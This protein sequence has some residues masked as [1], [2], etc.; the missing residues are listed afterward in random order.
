MTATH[1]LLQKKI[2]FR[3]QTSDDQVAGQSYPNAVLPQ[4]AENK[5]RRLA[6]IQSVVYIDGSSMCASPRI[7]SFSRFRETALG[8]WLYNADE[9]LCRENIAAVID[10]AHILTQDMYGIPFGQ[11]LQALEALRRHIPDIPITGFAAPKIL[12]ICAI[13]RI[14]PEQ[15]LR[16][17]KNAGLTT[18]SG[19]GITL[20]KVTGVFETLEM[21]DWLRVHRA[22]QSA[23]LRSFVT[24]PFAVH[25]VGADL[26]DRIPQLVQQLAEIQQDEHLFAGVAAR[27]V[28]RSFAGQ[29]PSEALIVPVYQLLREQF[30]WE[31]VVSCNFQELGLAGTFAA[32]YAGADVI[33]A[34]FETAESAKQVFL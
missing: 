4:S 25:S 31:T 10:S 11:V 24:I 12:E 20:G 23:G 8:P 26:P 13:E 22:A 2:F 15:A 21:A 32:V 19:A 27:K 34:A 28:W 18:L 29:V 9:I 5:A 1:T 14:A 3:A 6:Q 16:D 33:S 17:L 7:G 30:G